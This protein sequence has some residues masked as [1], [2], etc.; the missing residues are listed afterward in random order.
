MKLVITATVLSTLCLMS[1]RSRPVVIEHE[2]EAPSKT[3]VI[4]KDH[5]HHFYYDG[6]WYSEPEHIH[7][8]D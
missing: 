7:I 2:T 3:V 1:C 4:E 5:A 8:V 6:H